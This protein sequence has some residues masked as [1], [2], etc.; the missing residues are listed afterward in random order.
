MR[1]R[2]AQA[3]DIAVLVVAADDGVMPQTVEAISHARAAEVPIVVAITKV[4]REDANTDRVRQQLVEQELV[5]EEWGGD[6][7]VIE[8]A[9]PDGPASTSCSTRSCSS[10]SVEEL[11]ANP[12]APRGAFVLESNLDSGRG[13][14]VTALVETGTLRRRR[15]DRRRRRLGSRPGD[16]RR[17][18]RSQVNEAGPSM[19]VEVLGLDDVPL[20]GD[21][22]RVAPDDK[23]AR[24]V[25]EARARRR[26]AGEPRAPDERSP[27]APGSR[28]SSRWCSGARSRR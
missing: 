5:P 15:A 4:D 23:M 24:T 13:P 26:R 25:A 18:R 21:E 1:A 19:P 22:L 10:P 17:P 27:A 11:A 6:T 2:G 8:V 9:A 20:A 12:K 28:T 14:V 16:V 7:I 3:T